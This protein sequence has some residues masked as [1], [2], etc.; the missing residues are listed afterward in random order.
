MRTL[1]DVKKE[2]EQIN[3]FLGISMMVLDNLKKEIK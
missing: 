2:Y 3:S 1:D